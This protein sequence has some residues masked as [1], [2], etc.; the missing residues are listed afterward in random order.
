M[1]IFYAIQATGNGHISRAIQL[2]PY[3]QKYGSVDVFLSGSNSDLEGPLP[4]RYRSKGISLFYDNHGAL[5]AKKILSRNQWR[6]AWKEARCLPVEKYDLVINDFEPITSKA[7]QLKGKHSIQL[8]HQASF[9]SKVAPRPT[10]KSILGELILK[11]YSTSSEYIGFHFKSYDEFILPPVIK[12]KILQAQPVDKGHITVYLS[13]FDQDF[14]IK[15][16]T[17]IPG[18]RFHIFL[19]GI[20]DVCSYQNIIF[21]PVADHLFSQSLIDCHGVITGGGFETPSEALFLK[22]K[23]MVIPLKNHYEQYCNAAALEEMCIDVV[24]SGKPEHWIDLILPWIERPGIIHEIIPNNV[25]E[26]ID[27]VIAKA[28]PG[29]YDEQPL[30]DWPLPVHD[31]MPGYR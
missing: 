23:L 1:K 21:F 24:K 30:L 19:A 14:F 2:M 22:K 27:K 26:T 17:R 31:L 15:K 13:G 12:Q 7:C 5:D 9:R 28:I 4:V 11:H 3:L 10:H 29:S 25:A 8:S 18:V 6:S 20:A 16:L